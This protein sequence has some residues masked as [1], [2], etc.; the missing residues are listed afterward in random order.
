MY[1]NW[2]LNF[3]RSRMDKSI[4]LLKDLTNFGTWM[5]DNLKLKNQYDFWYQFFCKTFLCKIFLHSRAKGWY[6]WY[7]HRAHMVLLQSYFSWN[8]I[9]FT[10]YLRFSSN[11]HIA[12]LLSH[13]SCNIYVR[14]TQAHGKSRKFI[15]VVDR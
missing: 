4:F 3:F 13:F 12:F 9:N 6:F 14:K 2:V 11:F 8:N 7:H 10:N 15:F 1:W 5:K